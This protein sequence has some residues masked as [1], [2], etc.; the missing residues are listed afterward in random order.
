MVIVYL[1]KNKIINDETLP[2][3][4]DKMEKQLIKKLTQF[5]VYEEYQV[6]QY[7]ENPE[8]TYIFKMQEI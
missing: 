7:L 5:S 6:K 3:L 1:D 4:P 8:N 2:P